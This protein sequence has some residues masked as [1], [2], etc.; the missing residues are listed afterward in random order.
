MLDKFALAALALAA[1]TTTAAAQTNPGDPPCTITTTISTGPNG[2]TITRREGCGQVQI[3]S[4]G[5]NTSG[6]TSS[7]NNRTRT[8]T[9]TVT[10]NTP[11]A[12][13]PRANTPPAPSPGLGGMTPPARPNWDSDFGA[14]NAGAHNAPLG[15]NFPQP[16]ADF[17]RI[18]LFDRADFR[19]RSIGITQ[20]TPN[21]GSRR[22][23][24]L[25]SSA[26]LAGGVW[27]L[28][29]EPNYAGECTRLT[30]NTDLNAANLGDTSS[31]I[32]RVRAAE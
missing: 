16:P 7:S 1:L 24:N 5:G 21:L 31:S 32:R 19:G 10:P 29:T 18:V 8:N 2:E 6:T 30:A 26:R 9:A 3:T 23:D 22:F 12:P 4:S 11:S 20:D 15:A 28:C 14:A 17:A 25:A 27:E 13:P